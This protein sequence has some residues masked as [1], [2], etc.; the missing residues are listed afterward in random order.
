MMSLNSLILDP[1]KKTPWIILEPGKVVILGRSI[2]EN[3]G[4]E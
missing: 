1:T 4:A 3:P 2:L